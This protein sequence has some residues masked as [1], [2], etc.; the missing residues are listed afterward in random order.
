M[1]LH[2]TPQEHENDPPEK[3]TVRK[4]GRRWQLLSTSGGVID[5]YDTKKDAETARTKGYIYDLYQKEG[6]WF[7]GQPVPGWKPYQTT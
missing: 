1:A 7:Q 6:R 4:S 3:W 5:T 2:L